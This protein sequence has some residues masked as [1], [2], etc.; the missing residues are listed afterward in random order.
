MPKAKKKA[1]PQPQSAAKRSQPAAAK[2]T[3]QKARRPRQAIFIMVDSQRWDMVNCYRQ[4]GLLTPCLDRLAAAGVRYERAYDCQP[5]CGPARSALFTGTWP[6]SNG[7]W[8]NELPLGAG[9]RNLGELLQRAKVDTGYIGKWHLDA[10]D[11]FGRGQAAPGWDP[12]AW[13]DMRNYLEELT[14]EDRVRSRRQKTIAEDPP[15]DFCFGHRVATRAQ[16]YL[17]DHAGKEF[18]LT[19]SFDEPH[20][21]YLCPKRFHDQYKDFSFPRSPNIDDDLHDKPEHLK[22]WSDGLPQWS[23]ATPKNDPSQWSTAQPAFYGCN[24]FVDMEIG[25]VLDA[26]DRHCPDALVIYTSDHGHM[27]LSHRLYIK[28]PAMFDEITRIPFIVR[29]PGHAPEGVV[30]PGPVSH[31]DLT[32]TILDFFGAAIPETIEG[33]SMLESIRDPR[34]PAHDIVFCEYGRYGL[35]H[36]GFAGFQPIRCAIDGRYKLVVN[37]LETDEFYD[38][39]A[40]PGEMVNRIADPA[41]AAQRDRLHDALLEWQYRTRDPMRTW[42]WERRP[43][44]TGLPPIKDWHYTGRDLNFVHAPD[45]GPEILDYDTGLP[46]KQHDR[47]M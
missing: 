18:F 20:G 19:V 30:A 26:I 37:L 24:G 36:D 43:W 35:A 9:V 15:D 5:L 29:W 42:R 10:S 21:P 32:P 7:S 22:K 39:Q 41:T 23:G 2:P 3:A 46:L 38:M 17:A 16:D 25:R 13:Y 4:T 11:Y 27:Q 12:K 45:D 47:R 34:Q 1:K 8:S 40:D 6:H 14:P 33:R 44:R 31:I 28:G